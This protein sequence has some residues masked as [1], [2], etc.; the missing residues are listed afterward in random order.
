MMLTH[1]RHSP[2]LMSVSLYYTGQL[3]DDLS[4][5]ALYSAADVMV[6]P[7]RQDNLPNTGVEAHACGTPLVAFD[8]GGL[9]DIVEHQKTG[10]LAKAFDT[11]DL[12]RGV[13]WVLGKSSLRGGEADVAIQATKG[14]EAALRTAAR[15]KAVQA[16]SPKIVSAT[17]K[18][19]YEKNAR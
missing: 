2:R 1:M 19:V 14:S 17:Y 9:R 16:F 12:A 13:L 11:E 4:L 10:Y 8:I 7:S 15:S 3:H 6:I 18:S 5:R